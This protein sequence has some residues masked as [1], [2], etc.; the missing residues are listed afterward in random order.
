M[1]VLAILVVLLALTGPAQA[2]LKLN[3]TGTCAMWLE[4]G[5]NKVFRQIEEALVLGLIDGMSLGA[6]MNFWVTREGQLKINQ[7]LYWVDNYC[8]DNPLEHT[9]TGVWEFFNSRAE[10][11]E[12]S[13]Q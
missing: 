6:N 7:V 1:R 5:K 11:V 12:S 10:P 2:Q 9:V 3:A 4:A 8:R 13:D